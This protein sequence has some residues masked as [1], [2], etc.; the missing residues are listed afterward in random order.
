VTQTNPR[1]ADCIGQDLVGGDGERIGEIKDIYMDED[2]SQPEWFAVATGM[3]G[4]R[5]SFV[6]IQGASLSDNGISVSFDKATVKDAPHAEPDGQLSQ[7]EEAAL[8]AHYGFGYGESRS[9]SGLP[10]GGGGTKRRSGGDDAMTRSEEELVTGTRA[11]E[12]GRVRLV[13]YVETEHV[14]VTVPVQREK[15]RLVTEPITETNRDKAMDGPE[16]TEGVH[17]ETLYEEEPVVGKRTVPKERVRLE[18]ETV[19]DQRDVDA[20]LRKERIDVD[21]DAEPRR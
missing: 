16:I 17:E 9:S 5:V 19:T 4:R 14:N 3:F 6:P 7:D 18:K 10:E 20:D 2:T 11:K 13:K 15:A 12:A 21:G 8:Y 1:I